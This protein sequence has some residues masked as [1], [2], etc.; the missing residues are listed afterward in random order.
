[1]NLYCV[2][3]LEQKILRLEEK[4]TTLR[5][6]MSGVK[7]AQLTGLPK[8]KN[9]LSS[10]VEKVAQELIDGERELEELRAEQ[11]VLGAELTIEILRH[12]HGRAAR[13]MVMRYVLLNRFR[14]IAFELNLS[15]AR[16]YYIHAETLKKLK[17]C[18]M[19][20]GRD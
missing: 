4:I 20:I 16:I 5:E 2:R 12:V 10:R 9:F 11:R 19:E 13:I 6:T 18:G 1:M 15:D 7:P 3:E 17:E 14:D 8:E